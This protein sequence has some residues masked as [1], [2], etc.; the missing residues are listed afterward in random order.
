MR[1]CSQE[2]PIQVERPLPADTERGLRAHMSRI[3]SCNKQKRHFIEK[4]IEGAT[5]LL[6]TKTLMSERMFFTMD[7][8]DSEWRQWKILS[9]RKRWAYKTFTGKLFVKL[10]FD[11]CRSAATWRT[12]QNHAHLSFSQLHHV[13]RLV[14]M[15]WMWNMEQSGNS[16]DAVETES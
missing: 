3:I 5:W 15:V 4:S 9:W 10:M 11:V 8:E 16:W 13:T 6:K 14:L 2:T 7:S 1:S 12:N